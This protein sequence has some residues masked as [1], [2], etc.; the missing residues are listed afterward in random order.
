M[1]QN[2]EYNLT[3]IQVRN[4]KFDTSNYVIIRDGRPV[5]DAKTGQLKGTTPVKH[6]R[7][8]N[9]FFSKEFQDFETAYASFG[10][11]RFAG[12]IEELNEA[13]DAVEAAAKEQ[14]LDKLTQI[15]QAGILLAKM[16]QSYMDLIGQRS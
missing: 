14:G 9:E 16:V 11:I 10:E 7:T 5:R 15:E 4:Y 12:L 13:S 3:A 2:N 6:F 8:L 1:T